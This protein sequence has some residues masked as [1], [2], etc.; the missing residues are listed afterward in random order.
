VTMG[1]WARSAARVDWSKTQEA[2]IIAW[3]SFC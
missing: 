3:D 2:G 1:S